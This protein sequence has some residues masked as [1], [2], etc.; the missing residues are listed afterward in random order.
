MFEKRT[1]ENGERSRS[2]RAPLV[3]IGL[4]LVLG[5][6]AWAGPL[7]RHSADAASVTTV[8]DQQ[9]LASPDIYLGCGVSTYNPYLG[10]YYGYGGYGMSSFLDPYGNVIAP[11]PNFFSSCF[12]DCSQV[13]AAFSNFNVIC[14]GPPASVEIAP[15]PS[16]S[17]CGSAENITVYVRD[18]F[19]FYVA[20]GTTVNFSTSL[21]YITAT[22]STQSGTAVAS[23]VIPTKTAGI[24]TIYVSA[25]QATASKSI[26]VYC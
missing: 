21:G 2:R 15:S 14:P 5:F 17:S 10:G 6:A 19:G 1:S 3:V 13:Y 25:G 22:P 12:T 8:P 4:A 18:M 23:L 7:D 9:V 20:D 24:A 26:P 11:Y 16:Q